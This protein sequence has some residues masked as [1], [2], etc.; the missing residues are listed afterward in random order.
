MGGDNWVDLRPYDPSL[1]P[2]LIESRTFAP[3][4]RVGFVNLTQADVLLYGVAYDGTEGILDTYASRE[5]S[6]DIAQGQL[7]QIWL[8]KDLDGRN[9]AVF[10]TLEKTGR[11]LIG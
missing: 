1:L 10:Q 9:L 5:L 4:T 6:R 2:S 3:T 8:I 7:V 11:I